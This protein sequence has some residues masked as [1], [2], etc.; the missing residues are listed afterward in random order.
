MVI[1]KDI[2]SR[3]GFETGYHI[4]MEDTG[5]EIVLRRME[6]EEP[7][8]EHLENGFPVIVWPGRTEKEAYDIVAEIKKT[9]DD[10]DRKFRR[11]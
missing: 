8:I 2:R 1:P 5:T 7:V 9:R 3:Y 6:S 11:E 10:R 4:E